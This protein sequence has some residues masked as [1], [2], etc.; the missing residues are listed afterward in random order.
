MDYRRWS[1]PSIRFINE[2][3]V[4]AASVALPLV[5]VA[6]VG[7]R[8]YVR[9]H[10]E[11][12]LGIDDWL[13]ALG[14][15]M[16]IGIG[17]CFITGQQL[18]VVG[19]PTP[20]PSGTASPEEYMRYMGS[21]GKI[22]FAIQVLT[23]FSH[24]SIKTSIIFFARRIFVSH[25]YSPFD[26]ASWILIIL[27]IAWSATFLA[28]VIFSCGKNLPLRW[29]PIQSVDGQECGISKPQEALVIS[30]FILDFFIIILPIPSVWSL[31]MSWGKKLAVTGMFL[32]GIMSLAAS[33]AQLV[34]YFLV[35]YHSDRSGIDMNE[36]V[37]T[38]LWLSMIENSVAAIASCLPTLTV[39]AKGTRLRNF[40][41]RLSSGVSHSGW[42]PLWKTHS[43]S[44]RRLQP[45]ANNS[46]DIS[47]PIG[48]INFRDRRQIQIIN[49][50]AF[51]RK[52]ESFV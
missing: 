4:L 6:L 26:R 10:Q 30:D 21:Q 51:I 37:T 50:Q 13:L 31:N 24:G 39:L 18:G 23:C 34:I 11:T 29:A 22:E 35:L 2:K 17:V 16:I 28:I 41:Y 48:S 52:D 15:L 47:Y 5:C 7:T 33:T 43:G 49:Q 20:T 25:R 3:E 45:S 9:R 44:R 36:A 46:N 32:V 12:S 8:F 19:H 40:S 38:M 42:L 14:V 1:E 27:S